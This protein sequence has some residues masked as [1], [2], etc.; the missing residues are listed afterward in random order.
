MRNEYPYIALQVKEEKGLLYWWGVSPLQ[1][2]GPR[3]RSTP[4]ELRTEGILNGPGARMLFLVSNRGHLLWRVVAGDPAEAKVIDTFERAMAM[5]GRKLFVVL[6]DE[7]LFRSPAFVAWS[8]SQRHRIEFRTMPA[9][10]D[11]DVPDDAGA[12]AR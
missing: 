3:A 12:G 8:C 2:R 7:A 10:G 1:P 11:A 6:P 5:V 4:H 9:I